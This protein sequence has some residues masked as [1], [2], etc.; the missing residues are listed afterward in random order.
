MAAPPP[1]VAP[2]DELLSVFP[3][4]PASVTLSI[5]DRTDDTNLRVSTP[6]ISCLLEKKRDYQKK[7]QKS[8]R[9][10]NILM[11]FGHARPKL[12]SIQGNGHY[13]AHLVI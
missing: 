5:E 9:S 2:P 10:T 8:I 6:L 12:F 7:I 1:P 3:S 11:E 13:N 4:A